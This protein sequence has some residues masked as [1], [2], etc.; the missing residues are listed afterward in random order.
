MRFSPCLLVGLAV[1]CLAGCGQSHQPPSVLLLTLDTLRADALGCY[2]NQTVKTPNLDTL[3]REGVLFEDAVCQIPATLTSH[4]AIMTGRHPKTTGVRFRT[5]QVDQAEITLAERFQEAGYA[6]AAFLS[7]SVLA[8]VHQLDQGFDVYNLGALDE[9][10]GNATRERI[11]EDT[12]D[13]AL[14]YLN[15]PRNKPLFLWVHL[16]DPH[17]PY[18]AP[19]PYT[20]MFDPDYTGDFVGST[21]EVVRLNML[22][23]KGVT[24]RDLQHLRARY[25]GEVTYMDAQLGRLFDS[26]QEHGVWENLII[27]AL[28]DHGE[29]FGEKGHFF[30][31]GEIYQHS[32][33]IPFILWSPQ[34]LPP[35]KRV[36]TLAQT[37]DFYPTLLELVNMAVEKPVDGRSLLPLVDAPNE[38]QA[39]FAAQPAFLESEADP[40]AKG[41]KLIGLRTET[42]KFI[43]N[44]AHR[45]TDVPLGIYTEIPLKG[46]AIVMARTKGEPSVRLM[47]HVRYRTAELYTSRD[48]QALSQLPSTVVHG[49]SVGTDP[50]QREAMEAA[51]FLPTPEGWRLHMTPDIYRV[52]KQ[53]GESM[54]WET[55]H[56]VIEAVGIDASLPHT[57]TEAQ[58]TI[59]QIELYSPA[60]RFPNSPKYRPPFWIIA[61][62]E[63]LTQPGLQDSGEGPAH[64]LEVSWANESLFTGNRQQVIHIQFEDGNTESIDE[65][66]AVDSDPLEQTN[67]LFEAPTEAD[68]QIANDARSLLELWQ[69]QEGGALNPTQLD[70]DR[71][72]AL[73]SLGYLR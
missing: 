39:E 62:F 19:E 57:Q 63:D 18:Q 25:D 69:Q 23:G 68:R 60:L 51:S 34:L 4:T 73:Q 20:T 61:N 12:I 56:M 37:I 66:F 6:T 58:F 47:A 10:G 1:L 32:M 53:Y 67:L 44:Q 50:L 27:A 36:N 11:A 14:A 54:G 41:N 65:L 7:S 13:E 15:Q 30:H 33:R 48:R 35:G 71:L 29:A 21:A 26:L 40:V 22:K 42:H 8:S 28:S 17:S 3:A 72:E 31:G 2:G 43:Y 38:E 64:R 16:Y 45:R 46:P 9:N 55:E 59:D 52:A 5:A 24:E 49:E 70:E